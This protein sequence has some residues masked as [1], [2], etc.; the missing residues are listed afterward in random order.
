M[1]TQFLSAQPRPVAVAGCPRHHPL[2]PLECAK[3][4]K[5]FFFVTSVPH[6]R[7]VIKSA[8]DDFVIWSKR[9]SRECLFYCVVGVFTFKL[10]TLWS[11]MCR[12]KPVYPFLLQSNSKWGSPHPV[13]AQTNKQ[14]NPLR[15][16]VVTW[17][18]EKVLDDL[19]YL[20]VDKKVSRDARKLMGELSIF[21]CVTWFH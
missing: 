6:P 4:R 5:Y 19:H 7:R 10:I 18:L 17:V 16:F 15:N 2:A 21:K 11:P 12:G 8:C 14:K 13:P 1:T 3:W 9:F 20:T